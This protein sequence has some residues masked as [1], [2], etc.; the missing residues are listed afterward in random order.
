MGCTRTG[1]ETGADSIRCRPL[2]TLLGFPLVTRG[3]SRQTKSMQRLIRLFAPPLLL[4]G[5]FG[6]ATAN[7]HQVAALSLPYTEFDQ[8]Y[9]DGW[10]VLLDRGDGLAAVALI[11]AYLKKHSELTF[12]QR[13]FL[14]LHAAQVL[15][16][17][18][19]TNRAVSHLDQAMSYQTNPELWPD[20]DDFIIAQKAF[21]MHDRAS[22]LDARERLAAANAPRLKLADRLIEKFGQSYANVIWWIRVC[23]GIVIPNTTGP[24]HRA[25]AERLAAALGCSITTTD[26]QPPSCVVW[27]EVRSFS[28]NDAPKGYVIIHSTDGTAIT[29]SDPQWLDDAVERF[30]K[31]ARKSNGYWEAPFGL[32]SNYEFNPRS[33][34][35]M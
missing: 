5:L 20:W 34:Q 27:L 24:R 17:E 21:L 18:G 32:A 6:C 16:L 13:K 7:H 2:K 14:H 11:E 4:V 30:L 22:L 29:A 31:S 10:R 12:G 15:A 9:G 3:C 1:V 35:G 33:R 25:A 19:K 8:A 23:P 28:P 26:T